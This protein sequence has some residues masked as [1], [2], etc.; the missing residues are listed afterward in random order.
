MSSANT[1]IT[2]TPIYAEIKRLYADAR[3]PGERRISDATDLVVSHDGR[4]VAFTGTVAEL[5]TGSLPTRICQLE[6][7]TGEVEILTDSTGSARE[8][9]FSPD[10]RTIAFLS[11]RSAPSDFQL[12][13]L[14]RD[15]RSQ[16]AAP[17]LDGWIEYMH[18][19]PDGKTILLGVAAHGADRA[20]LHGAVSSQVQMTQHAAA[21]MPIVRGSFDAQYWR[22]VWLYDVAEN[23]VR[24][25]SPP[26]LNVWEAVWCGSNAYVAVASD[27]TYE[28]S[29]YSAYLC[30]VN[31]GGNVARKVYV[32]QNQVGM[33]AASPSGK[34]VAFIEAVCSDRCVVAGDLIL[35]DWATGNARAIDT[36]GTDVAYIEWRSD[37]HLLISGQRND[38]SA[39]CVLD[40]PNCRLREI[41]SS[42]EITTGGPYFRV[43]G[44][45][46][47]G[48][49]VL[50]G[51]GFTRAPEIAEIRKGA[52]RSLRSLHLSTEDSRCRVGDVQS[53]RWVAP[54][55]LEIE[56]WLLL[57]AECSERPFPT[58]MHV[59]AGPV[60]HW[61]PTWLLR[62]RAS[63]LSL[64]LRGYAGFLPN[65][66]GSTGRGQTFVRHVVG[67]MGGGDAQDLL[68][69][70]DYLVD[71][72]VADRDRIGV[73]GVSYG[74]YMASWLITQDP[75]FAAAV[76]I[77]AITNYVTQRL[78]SNIPQWP[79]RFLNDDYFNLAGRFFTRSPLMYAHRTVTPTLN[80]CGALDRSTPAMEAEQFHNA[81]I[82]KGVESMLV[83]YPL[84]GHGVR[85]LPAAI[86]CAA[87]SVFWFE[88]HL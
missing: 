22:Q 44:M 77:A 62:G 85:G 76:P 38:T 6:L 11:D 14:D 30:H 65:P 58:I 9:K 64:W 50:V 13:L 66:R 12:F 87:R 83:T 63:M 8:P 25:A 36:C 27:A 53:V 88:E 17:V 75:R 51:E 67:D 69:G 78:I 55:G 4:F 54:D 52:Y 34:M 5:V 41:W 56:G 49:C 84:E 20:A 48:D 35:L 32:P 19:S 2:S 79:D 15:R 74:G 31:I 37:C 33:P 10:D 82:E 7:P 86:D 18:W 57:P 29:W 1:D 73:T 71:S 24:R 23:S 39:V 3:R 16:W 21:W 72:G 47:I 70:L 68:S 46:A 28:G 60:W 43:A 80:I 61:R 81:L 45:G 40:I 59:H 26:G 42:S